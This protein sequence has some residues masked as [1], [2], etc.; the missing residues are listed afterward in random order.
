MTIN[1]TRLIGS[2]SGMALLC[3]AAPA[4]AQATPQGAAPTYA[5]PAA[6]T[7]AEKAAAA[8]DTG[9]EVVVTGI[10]ASLAKAIEIK[11]QATDQVDAISATDIGKLPDKNVADALQR[12][13]GVNTTSAAS[14]EAVAP[15]TPI[16]TPTSA[17]ARAGASLMPSPTMTTMPRSR[18]SRTTS[19][20][21]A[22]LR[23]A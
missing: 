17:A 20:F 4:F 2:V 19:T 21:S 6:Q 12:L 15:R 5:T 10:R 13:P 7:A 11:K 18:S 14:D 8:G 22:G 9:G 3:A 16:A 23:S 1:K